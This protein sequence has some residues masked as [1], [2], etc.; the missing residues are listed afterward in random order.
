VLQIVDI[1]VS[2]CVLLP[3]AFGSEY[4]FNISLYAGNKTARQRGTGAPA[5]SRSRPHVPTPVFAIRGSP[6]LARRSFNAVAG[7][8]V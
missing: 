4:L 7:R 8:V 1:F 5:P 3:T 2:D 6:A